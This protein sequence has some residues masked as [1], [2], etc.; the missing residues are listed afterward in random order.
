LRQIVFFLL[1][2]FAVTFSIAETGTTMTI[3]QIK[4]KY[5]VKLMGLPGVVSVGIG[6][7][8]EEMVIKVGLDGKH[9]LKKHCQKRWR[10]TGSSVRM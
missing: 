5:Q 1:L 3:Q 6:L 7:S 4:E 2:F 9:S 8:D 10:D